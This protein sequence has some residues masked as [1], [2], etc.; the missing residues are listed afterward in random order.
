M[1]YKQ[2]KFLDEYGN[3]CAGLYNEERDEVICG[4]C[5]YVFTNTGEG[6]S[7]ALLKTYDWR[8]LNDTILGE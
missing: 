5:G 3:E 4:C 8:N 1:L 6:H 7:F 2:C